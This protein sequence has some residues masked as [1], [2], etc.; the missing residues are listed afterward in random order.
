MPIFIHKDERLKREST[1]ISSMLTKTLG[2]A[3][4]EEKHDA[5]IEICCWVKK[6]GIMHVVEASLLGAFFCGCNDTLVTKIM[7]ESGGQLRKPF[8]N[9]AHAMTGVAN[10]FG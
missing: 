5:I 10:F 1:V 7:G 2:M 9:G 8:R 3:L 6:M 4:A